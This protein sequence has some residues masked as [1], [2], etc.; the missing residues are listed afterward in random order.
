MH[1][2][3]FSLIALVALA[4]LSTLLAGCGKKS[5]V[6]VN[7]ESVSRE[8]FV[9][10]LEQV[11]VQTQQG[12]KMA[13]QYVIEQIIG[14]K[15]IAELA[16]KEK[17]APTEAQI[18]KKITAIKKESGGDLKKVL[19]QRGM[20]M[21]DLKKQLTIQQALVNVVSKDVK[22]PDADVKKAYDQALA[23]KNSPFKRPEQV[24]V[25]VIAASD[26]NAVD[27]AY[28]LISG[29]TDFST[30]AMQ[31][32]DIPVLKQSQGKLG[33][34][35]KGDA[36]FGAQIR[37][38]AF[39]L[40]MGKFSKPFKDDDKWVIVKAERKRDAYTQK[41]DDVKDMIREQM[42]VAKGSQT[43]TFRKDMQKFTKDADIVVG[44]ERYKGVVDKIKKEAAASLE[45]KLQPAGG[46][47]TK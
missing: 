31:T 34:V 10:R 33:W 46:K 21:D 40:E 35:S 39:S 24:F 27:K 23:A 19:A 44:S 41:Y 12:T 25:S 4:I 37:S 30:V 5:M 29:G 17:V 45:E 15:L 18:E 20:T 1:K 26:K 7:G 16:E 9:S 22:I 28:K 14:E 2:I 32:N 8:E 43:G 3:R 42:A 13:G 38:Y 36:Q 47:A 11:P 6:K